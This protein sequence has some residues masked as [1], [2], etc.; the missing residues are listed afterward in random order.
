METYGPPCRVYDCTVNNL[1]PSSFPCFS[2][3][4]KTLK[5]DNVGLFDTSIPEVETGV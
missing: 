5:N 1:T 3:V 4:N 2:T